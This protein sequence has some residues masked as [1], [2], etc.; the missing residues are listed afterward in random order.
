MNGL[1]YVR[2][3]PTGNITLL[4]TDPVPR[5][6]QPQIA[7]RIMQPD[8][9]PCEQVGFLE[10]AENRQA[11]ARLQMMGGEFCGNATMSVAAW[12]ANLQGSKPGDTASVPLE[13][14]G[15]AEVLHCRITVLNDGFEGTIRMPAVLSVE[16]YGELTAVHM[17]GIVHL[18]AEGAPMAPAEAESLL[19]RVSKDF[20]EDA[21]GL[22]QWRSGT[23][24][25]LVYVKSTGTAVWETGCGSGSAAIGMLEALRGGK[26]ETVTPVRQPGGCIT[27]SVST[28]PDKSPLLY[29]TGKVRI[30]EKGIFP[31]FP[32]T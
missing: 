17:D 25:P 19:H 3:D 30:L 28:G 1:H 15:A 13:V 16:K 26:A 27:A 10:S 32:D 22:L 23:M 21:V 29:I 9:I 4:V 11:A 12:I 7:A 18:I 31:C 5:H 24:T 2:F 20:R 8:G 14:S 6:L